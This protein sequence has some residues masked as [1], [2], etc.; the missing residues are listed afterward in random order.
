MTKWQIMV[1]TIGY[2]KQQFEFET[3]NKYS[4]SIFHFQ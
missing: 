2:V 1:I 3:E 4:Y